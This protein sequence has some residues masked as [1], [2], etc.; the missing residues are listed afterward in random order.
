MLF[1]F[2]G[3]ERL[4]FKLRNLAKYAADHGMIVRQLLDA[5]GFN[6][7]G[8][9]EN[10]NLVTEKA[11]GKDESKTMGQ[12]Y[13]KARYRGINIDELGATE[14]TIQF[15]NAGYDPW[16]ELG[17]G[18]VEVYTFGKKSSNTDE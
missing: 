16:K 12:K 7:Y 14:K 5:N 8:I 13:H 15:M 6:T 9:P 2:S 17:D 4:L 1:A 3:G 18:F 10:A 11:W